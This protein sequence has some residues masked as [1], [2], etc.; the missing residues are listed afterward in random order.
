[1]KRLTERLVLV[2]VLV[3]YLAASGCYASGGYVGYGATHD[4]YDEAF[5]R[6]PIDRYGYG[7]YGH[8]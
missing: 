8:P 4:Y 2:A 6:A 7:F 5:Y 1:M 3:L